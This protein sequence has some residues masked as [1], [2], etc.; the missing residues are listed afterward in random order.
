VSDLGKNKI[1]HAVVEVAGVLDPS[2]SKAVSGAV[3]HLDKINWKAVAVGAAV[4]G[5]AVAAGKAVYE[6]GQYL[7]DLGGQFDEV[8]DG[9]RIG[10]GATGEA[11]DGLLDDFDAV[12]KGVPASMEDASAAI[13]DYNTRLGLTGPALQ[14]LSK[15]A[16]Q[17][18]DMLG[19]DLNTVI[20]SSSQA[21]Q[22]WRL[23][24]DDMADA[25][26]Y[27]FKV[28]QSTGTGF[29]DLMSQVQKF[30]PQLQELG[31]SF[32]EAS[33]LVGQ[34]E[35][36]GVNTDE[37]LGA[38]KKSV[39]ALAKEGISASD[40]IAMYYDE[41]MNAATAADAAAIASEVFGARAG[42]TMAAAIRDGTLAVS[43]FT[44]ELMANS[45]SISGA[46][47]D[48]YDFSERLQMFKQNAEVALKPLANT[49]FDAINDALP[50]VM[51]AL[52]AVMP[53]L[54]LLG[55]K[56][57]PAIIPP[58][59]AIV[60]GLADLVTWLFSTDGALQT[61]AIILG[62]ITA[63]VIAYNIQQSLAAAGTTLW[64]TVSGI[65]AGATTALG[66]AFAFLTSPIGLII[67]AIGAVIAIG[68]L[69][70]KNW[71]AVVGFLQQAGE[72]LM[73]FFSAVGEFLGNVFKAPINF[74]IDGIN[75]FLSGLNML[76]IPDWVPGIG[77]FGINIPLIPRLATGGFTD[78]L[79]LAG[80]AGVEAVIS[81]DPAYR[82]ENIEYW[83]Q[84]GR[85]LGV[86]GNLETSITQPEPRDMSY[87]AQTG[88][89]LGVTEE[90]NITNLSGGG[91]TTVV[92][93]L[94]EVS[95]APH[96]EVK[97]S[98]DADKIIDKIKEMEPEFFDMLE[99]WL[100]RREAGR[101]ETVGSLT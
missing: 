93:E 57:F 56:V 44:A 22:Q 18:S 40:G 26:D 84:A 53:V 33:A 61:V 43:D 31:Y 74:I 4:G 7:A 1:L 90:T 75:M 66:A 35:K 19:D 76:K 45:E 24:S 81:F 27:I 87:A 69:L 5:I 51:E 55:E 47:E 73:S 49:V 11:L 52:N 92:Y 13:A 65:A 20:E 70:A 72:K 58:V 59:T 79:S 77:G 78:G 85:I 6:A 14:E 36:A 88:Y 100:Q 80:E 99:D 46:A 95:F 39:G 17:V 101:Y 86:T 98:A 71:D 64:A 68:V 48:T 15:Q 28:S 83:A 63:L 41:I 50:Y 29:S 2:L 62:T 34:L 3:G 8:A 32:E 37:V 25:M 54:V 23:D 89:N 21:F 42:S 16:L 82:K 91:A 30:G 60:S 96:I 97:G 9:I 10:T 12:Y 94:G 38:L 67:L